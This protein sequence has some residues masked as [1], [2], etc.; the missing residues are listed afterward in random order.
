MNAGLG[1]DLNLLSE[2][3]GQ[4]CEKTWYFRLLAPPKPCLRAAFDSFDTYKTIKG[5]NQRKDGR[6]KENLL[7]YFC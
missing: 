4:G 2:I 3:G 5:Q 1:P 7:K 6:K